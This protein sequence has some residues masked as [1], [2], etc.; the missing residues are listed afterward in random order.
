LGLAAD[1]RPW[2][3]AVRL[4]TGWTGIAHDSAVI[5]DGTVT[6]DITSCAGSSRPCGV[7]SFTGPIANPGAA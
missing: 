7:C 3:I 1:A 6:V 4:D 5:S 2:P